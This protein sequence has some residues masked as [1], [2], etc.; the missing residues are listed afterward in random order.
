MITVPILSRGSLFASKDFAKSINNSLPRRRSYGFVT[1]SFLS[2][3]RGV[4]T[5]D[6]PLRT[7]A[8][9]ATSTKQGQKVKNIFYV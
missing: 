2:H 5:R 4:G 3:V 1:Q 8:W 7:F 9:E 6:E